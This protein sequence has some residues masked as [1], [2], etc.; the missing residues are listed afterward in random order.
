[1][2][3]IHKSK[4]ICSLN[5]FVSKSIRNFY[6]CFNQNLILFFDMLMYFIDMLTGPNRLSVKLLLMKMPMLNLFVNL[7]MKLKDSKPCLELEAL[8]LMVIFITC[9][10]FQIF[11]CHMPMVNVLHLGTYFHLFL[12]FWGWNKM[13]TC[14]P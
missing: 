14:Y 8:M 1:M 7:K 5:I 3:I 11:L 10:C 2:N 13:Y 12:C 4:N 9:Y 6:Y